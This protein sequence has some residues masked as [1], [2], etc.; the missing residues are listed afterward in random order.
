MMIKCYDALMRPQNRAI[1]QFDST[2]SESDLGVP[3]AHCSL[4]YAPAFQWWCNC[5]HLF[6]SH[7]IP[8]WRRVSLDTKRIIPPRRKERE[9]FWRIARADYL[10]LFRL[11]IRHSVK[12]CRRCV[13]KLRLLIHDSTIM[14][15][16]MS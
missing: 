2:W 7:C 12:I 14:N 9:L 16:M 3:V 10:S 6:A 5:L 15:L 13:D 11:I 1:S 8:Q 4:S